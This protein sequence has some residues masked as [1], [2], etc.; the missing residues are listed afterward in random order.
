MDWN[1][2]AIR[3]MTYLSLTFDHRIL[4]EAIADHFLGKIVT[5]LQEWG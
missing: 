4:D 2:I 1:A 3:P 5:I